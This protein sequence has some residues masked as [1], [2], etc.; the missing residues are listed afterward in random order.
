MNLTA[1]W[2]FFSWLPYFHTPSHTT[3]CLSLDSRLRLNHDLS[4]DSL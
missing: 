3:L 4:H 2:R 1:L